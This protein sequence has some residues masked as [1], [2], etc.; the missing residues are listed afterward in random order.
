MPHCTGNSNFCFALLEDRRSPRCSPC[1]RTRRRRCP[2]AARS[3]PCRCAPRRTPCRRRARRA[4]SRKMYLRRVL[5]EVGVVGEVGERDLRLDHPE[6]GEVPA[7][8]RVLGAERR[9]ER[10]DLRQ[11]EAVRLDVELARHG[12]ERLACRRSPARSRPCRRACAAGSRGRACETRN[13]SPAPSAS[14]RGDDRRV[15]P[16]RSRARGRS[17]GSPARACGA[18]GVT[19]PNMLVRGRRC[20]TS[21]RYSN[22]WRL[23]WI[24]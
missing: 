7:G 22:V 19:A 24:G 11:R 17:G 10:V 4:P 2:R 12:E 20:A 1:A 6:L 3:R 16:D 9:P 23:G 5:G 8:V 14:R 21:R 15:D 13:S 18:R